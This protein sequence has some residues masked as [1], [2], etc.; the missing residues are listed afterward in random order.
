MTGRSLRW[1]W[2]FGGT[3]SLSP[4]CSLSPMHSMK[5]FLTSAE[6]NPTISTLQ[7]AYRCSSPDAIGRNV[8]INELKCM[9]IPPGVQMSCWKREPCWSP[10]P[11]SSHPSR[12]KST[13]RPSQASMLDCNSTRMLLDLAGSISARDLADWMAGSHSWTN[14]TT[15][16]SWNSSPDS[17]FWTMH[18]AKVLFPVAGA[19]SI[20]MTLRAFSSSFLLSSL[21]RF[22]SS[23]DDFLLMMSSTPPFSVSRTSSSSIGLCWMVWCPNWRPCEWVEGATGEWRT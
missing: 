21:K 14:T 9:F 15:L 23:I 4:L 3:V 5:N 16:N 22:S 1:F 12:T 13:P 19:P 7:E 18:Q 8:M 10:G 6:V 17:N 2:F 20:R 11:S